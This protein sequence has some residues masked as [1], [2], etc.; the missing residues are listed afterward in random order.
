MGLAIDANTFTS[1]DSKN[2]QDEKFEVIICRMGD[3]AAGLPILKDDRYTDL[4]FGDL[5]MGILVCGLNG[6]GKSTFGKALAEKLGYH[7]IDNEDLYFPKSN[8]NYIY[9]IPRSEA[10][11]ESLLIKEVRAHENFV[12][13][14]VYGDHGKEILPFYKC[15]I[16]LKVPKEVR[17]QRVRDRSFQKFGDRMLEGGDLY[18]KEERFFQL[19]SKRSEDSVEKWARSLSCPVIRIDGTKPVEENINFI[20]EE[21][22]R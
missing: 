16:V 8:P 21:I 1:N 10:E 6:S 13:A 9:A 7:F 11:V 15:A 5:G 18:E 14:A 17:M 4:N 19:V 20:I 3:P 22:H 2:A 12:F